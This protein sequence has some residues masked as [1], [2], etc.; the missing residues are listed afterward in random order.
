M[1]RG[2]TKTLLGIFH[3]TTGFSETVSMQEVISPHHSQMRSVLREFDGVN[4]MLKI[5][6]QARE[7]VND[8]SDTEEKRTEQLSELNQDEEKVKEY[9]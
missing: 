6:N 7:R 8:S 1:S 4:R 5:T 2:N 9:Y 3:A